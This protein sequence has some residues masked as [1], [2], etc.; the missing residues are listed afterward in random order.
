MTLGDEVMGAL[1]KHK[2]KKNKSN[3]WSGFLKNALI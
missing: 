3:P 1:K 2:N